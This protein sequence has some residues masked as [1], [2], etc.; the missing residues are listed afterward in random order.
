ML[1]AGQQYDLDDLMDDLE[2]GYRRGAGPDQLLEVGE[3][4]LHLHC[5]VNLPAERNNKW[6]RAE[7]TGM[8][9]GL[10][11]VYL[12]DMGLVAAVPSTPC[13][14]R[15]LLVQFTSMPA[16]AVRARLDLRPPGSRWQEDSTDMFLELTSRACSAQGV[17]AAGLV[18]LVQGWDQ[19]GTVVVRLFDTVTNSL[20]TGLE[21]G[22]ALVAEG[23]ARHPDVPPALLP[24]PP[25]SGEGS[26]AVRRLLLSSGTVHLV[27]WRGGTWLTSAA[28]AALHGGWRGYDLLASVLAR[29]GA[30]FDSQVLVAVEE[31]EL[32]GE[33]VEQE[34]E[35][36]VNRRGEAVEQ[37]EM[38]R[39]VDLVNILAT[40]NVS[41]ESTDLAAIKAME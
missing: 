20:P 1:V 27:T 21:V 39:F 31:E 33:L 6:Y 40:I 22:E 34:V 12:L 14:L 24:Q 18:A 38:Y 15:R 17:E 29:R 30:V 25:R 4:V 32:W 8:E 5:A 3:L 35:G 36:L 28:V 26:S 10:V 7:V 41:L 19:D 2:D 37:L 11:Q 13:H 9:E 16:Q 23:L